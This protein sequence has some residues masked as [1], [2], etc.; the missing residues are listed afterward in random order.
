MLY[1]GSLLVTE[2]KG[3]T[4]WI[5]VKRFLKV[6]LFMKWGKWL[7]FT[8]WALGIRIF[9][10]DIAFGEE[11]VWIGPLH[12]LKWYRRC[13]H[14]RICAWHVPLV[15]GCVARGCV[16]FGLIEEKNITKSEFYS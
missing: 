2:F 4:V 6:S 11:F 14:E 9:S 10:K 3:K 7:I 8:Y 12:E 1:P 13:T 5:T 16:H 15:Y